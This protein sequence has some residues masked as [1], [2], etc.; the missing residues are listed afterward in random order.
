MRNFQMFPPSAAP[1]ADR[2]DGVEQVRRLSRNMV[3]EGLQREQ[4]ARL[5]FDFDGSVQSTR[6]TPRA[7]R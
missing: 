1:D 2:C 3:L 5:T 4:F 6:A 7:R